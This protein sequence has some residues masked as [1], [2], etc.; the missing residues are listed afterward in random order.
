MASILYTPFFFLVLSFFVVMINSQYPFEKA[1]DNEIN[2]DSDEDSRLKK[3]TQSEDES[4]SS[5]SARIGARDGSGAQFSGYGNDQVSGYSD[6]GDKNDIVAIAASAVAFGIGALGLAWYIQDLYARLDDNDDT[7]TMA[8]T[9]LAQ[10]E[11]DFDT[12]QTKEGEICSALSD[13]TKASYVTPADA[14][15]QDF[16]QYTYLQELTSI[17]INC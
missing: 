9:T 11:D 13:I 15:T 5:F 16:D 10:L 12:Y 7:I 17:S 8:T 14:K 2:V 3:S 6:D 4:K 1:T